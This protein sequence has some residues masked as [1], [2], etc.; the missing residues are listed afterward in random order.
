[1]SFPLT[2]VDGWCKQTLTDLRPLH[3]HPLGADEG[4]ANLSGDRARG[5]GALPLLH[6]GELSL[7]ILLHTEH[8]AILPA[9]TFTAG[10]RALGPG[11]L[12]PAA[13]TQDRGQAHLVLSQ[14]I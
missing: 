10:H 7:G 4:V 12:L 3:G 6:L 11:A 5:V 13:H 9:A 1:M 8:A 14:A 2:N